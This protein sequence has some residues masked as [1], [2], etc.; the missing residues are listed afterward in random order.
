MTQH[1][2]RDVE[3]SRC[4]DVEMLSTFFFSDDV[5]FPSKTTIVDD[6]NKSENGLDLSTNL[7]IQD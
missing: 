5:T 2:I 6:V 1:I 7:M 3:M 4:R